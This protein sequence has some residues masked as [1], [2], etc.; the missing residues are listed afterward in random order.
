VSRIPFPYIKRAPSVYHDGEDRVLEYDARLIDEDKRAT[1]TLKAGFRYRASTPRFAWSFFAPSDCKEWGPLGHDGLYQCMG[2]PASRP[3][4]IEV[5]PAGVTWTRAEAD[6]AFR[7]WM[8]REGVKAG[9]ARRAYYA[10]RVFG[11]SSWK[12]PG[13][14]A[15]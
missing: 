13:S 2:D 4:I 9:K 15:R 8:L 1:L 7:K 5:E 12:L 10:V 6:R 3:D 11:G 14:G